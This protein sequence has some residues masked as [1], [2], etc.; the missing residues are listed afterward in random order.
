MNLEGLRGAFRWAG[1]CLVLAAPVFGAPSRRTDDAKTKVE[2][3]KSEE[4]E[5]PTI[6]PTPRPIRLVASEV[7]KKAVLAA[8]SD[9][10][11][12]VSVK[13][14]LVG[15]GAYTPRGG[16]TLG[17]N[18]PPRYLFPQVG[19]GNSLNVDPMTGHSYFTNT[20]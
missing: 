14:G 13:G 19:A 20:P 5:R 8:P 12:R 1:A 6:A 7:I 16:D 10:A 2:K 17:A 3:S 4:E 11:R 18:A 15:L 9:T